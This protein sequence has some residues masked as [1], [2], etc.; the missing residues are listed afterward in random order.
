MAVH[1]RELLF[2]RR[3]HFPE[4]V[5]L[6]VVTILQRFDD[7]VKIVDR[8]DAIEYALKTATKGDIVV[9]AG[10]GHETTQV[11]SDRTVHFDDVE[12]AFD[13]LREMKLT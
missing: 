3:E 2:H 8:T 10:K 5:L 4:S 11:F 13:I 7:F 6:S 9:I 12:A 1:H